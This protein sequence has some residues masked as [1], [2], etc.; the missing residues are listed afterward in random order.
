MVAVIHF[1]QPIFMKHFSIKEIQSWDRYYR[2]NFINCL[3]GFKSATLVGTINEQ[4]QPNLAIFSNIVHIGADPAL[5][6]FINRPKAA[7]P[8]TLQNI[9]A[10]GWYSMNHINPSIIASAH[11][12]SAKY[13]ADINEFEATGLTTTYH[14][15]LLIPFVAESHIQYAMELVNIVP[16]PQNGTF[17]VI[18]AVKEVWIHQE[19][20]VQPDGYLDIEQAGSICS[21]GI[22]GY[23]TCKLTNR[24]AYAKP[25]EPTIIL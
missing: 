4:S 7:A 21:L 5:I 24:Y 11:Q 22:D 15:N 8:H 9:E 25:N 20:I 3:S 10:T 18:G 19:H 2:G 1:Q 14:N 6:G 16:I 23:Y 13:D 12:S 17:L